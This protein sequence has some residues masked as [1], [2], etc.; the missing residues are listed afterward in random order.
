MIIMNDS[1]CQEKNLCEKVR[2]RKK[3]YLGVQGR[4]DEQVRDSNTA[5]VPSKIIA[6]R[7]RPD[8]KKSNQHEEMN[9]LSGST[10][11]SG[12]HHHE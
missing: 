9:T 1:L 5:L 10:M 3:V 6:R 7:S 2:R 11:L 12:D 8:V 4:Q